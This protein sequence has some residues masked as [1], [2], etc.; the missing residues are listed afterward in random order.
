MSKR[1]ERVNGLADKVMAHQPP[2]K[3]VVEEPYE[4]AVSK[5]QILAEFEAKQL[6]PKVEDTHIRRTFL[7]DKELDARLT[8]LSRKKGHGFKTFFINQIIADALKELE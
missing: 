6:R 4:E 8:A 5:E 1:E 2:K 7:I 3:K